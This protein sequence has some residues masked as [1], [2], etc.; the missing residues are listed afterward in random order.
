MLIIAGYH[1]EINFIDFMNKLSPMQRRP[2]PKKLDINI[3]KKIKKN[4]KFVEKNSSL[5][6]RNNE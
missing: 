2:V 1:E 3:I 6:K 4:S 5:S